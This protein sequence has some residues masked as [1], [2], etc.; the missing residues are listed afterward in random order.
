MQLKKPAPVSGALKKLVPCLVAGI[1]GFSLNAA[2]PPPGTAEPLPG[3]AEPPSPEDTA[4][5]APT[6]VTAT[7]MLTPLPQ[8]GSA[9]SVIDVPL[10]QE[11]GIFDLQSALNGIPGVQS[12]ST[13]GQRGAIGSLFIRGTSTSDSQLIV[14]GVRLSDSTV[15]LGNFLGASSLDGFE[16]IEVLRGPQSALYGGEASGG[17]ISL[18]TARGQGDPGGMLRLEA[19]SFGS[20]QAAT[21]FSGVLGKLGYFL[22]TRYEETQND[23][24]ANDFSQGAFALRLDQQV[25]DELTIGLTARA[26]DG[27]YEDR[28]A[29][30]DHLDSSLLTLYANA[31]L[32]PVWTSNLIVGRYQESYDSDA[33][34]G[35]YATDLERLSVSLDN[36]IELGA[37]HRLAMGGFAENTDF[38]NTIGTAQNRDRYGVHAG[39][40]WR[41]TKE[42]TTYLAGRWEDYAAYGDE[43]TYRGTL[44]YQVT[45]SGTIL[46]TSYG[47]AFKTPTY[48]DLFGSDFGVGNPD[49]TAESSRG[50]D[51][52]IEQPIAKNHAVSLTW[53]ESHIDNQIQSFPAPPV[54]L[55]GTN[56]ASGLEADVHGSFSDGRWSY[57]AAYTFLQR[58]LRDLPAQT[59]NASLEFRPSAAWLLGAGAGFVDSR[60]YGGDPLD[61]YFLLRLHASYQMS[62]NVRLHARLE[63]ALNEDYQLSDFYGTR[64]DGRGTGIF[65]GVTI[66]W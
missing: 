12:T 34:F 63:N 44:A 50:W 55:S 58:A 18:E 2:E 14:D 7:R 28:G 6:V 17:V 54:N 11:R 57:R 30:V 61:A 60:S 43:L 36:Q 23:A 47:R 25:S 64:I 48:L 41:P 21:S 65:S 16:R 1:V 24:Q 66:S 52:G 32:S 27:F 9:V 13:A 38:A 62:K 42:L 22:G 53:F 31:R 5:L 10:Y 59:A 4:G 45:N 19:G 37:N 8:V 3:K 29:S 33:S 49:L 51:L 46:R 20:Y 56:R 26:N 40:E 39:W 15:P 35:N